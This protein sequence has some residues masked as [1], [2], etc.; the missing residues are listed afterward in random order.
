[1]EVERSSYYRPDEIL[2]DVQSRIERAKKV[3]ESIDYLTIVPDGEPTLDVNLSREIKLLK[4]LGIKIAVITNASLIWREDVREALKQTDWLSLKVDSVQEK[5][6]R[7]INRPHRGLQLSS[8]RDGMLEFAK[9]YEGVLVT[10]TMLVKGVNDGA[11]HVGEIADFL[12]QLRPCTA[13]VAI[14]IRPTAEK[15]VQSSHEDVINRNY[16]ILRKQTDRVEYLIGYE[17]NT[18]GFTGNLADDL[19]GITAVHPMREEAVS[20]FLARAQ[21]DWS[22]VDTLIARGELVETEYEGRRFYMR[23]P[24]FGQGE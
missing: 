2:G 13:Y 5:V 3:G 11:D 12:G 19:L 9:V 4:P 23:K 21:A 7:R 14:P 10:E 16:Q 24:H 22:I 6:W 8:I 20:D 15:W 18:F 17:G 1:M